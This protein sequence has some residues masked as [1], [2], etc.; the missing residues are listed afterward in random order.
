MKPDTPVSYRRRVSNPKRRYTTKN[1]APKRDLKTLF[2]IE[3]F[4][5]GEE[6]QELQDILIPAP[7]LQL[8]AQ[9]IVS[10]A[11]RSGPK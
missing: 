7:S 4:G 5:S 2:M 6:S 1:Y 10:D 8:L 9:S 3:V 11:H